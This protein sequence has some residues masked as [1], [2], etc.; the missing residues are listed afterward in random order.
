[1]PGVVLAAEMAW[2]ACV[3]AAGHSQPCTPCCPQPL[4][5][6]YTLQASPKYAPWFLSSSGNSFR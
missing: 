3:Q 6:S 1:M 5:L 2:A 4:T